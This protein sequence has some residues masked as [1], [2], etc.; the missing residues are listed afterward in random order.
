[1]ENEFPHS[2]LVIPGGCIVRPDS[3]KEVTVRYCPR[4]REEEKTWREDPLDRF[5][6]PAKQ[7]LLRVRDGVRNQLAQAFQDALDHLLPLALACAKADKA[8]NLL[9]QSHGISDETYET[10]R[11]D[12]ILDTVFKDLASSLE[13][14][15]PELKR[16]HYMEIYYPGWES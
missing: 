1:L 8:V 12:I 9:V 10:R 2:S 11:V 6:D 5:E 3:P 13:R 15:L 16:A 7:D 14:S 4:C